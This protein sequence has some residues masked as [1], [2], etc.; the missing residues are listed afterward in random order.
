MS[1]IMGEILFLGLSGDETT[2]PMELRDYADWELR[3]R[4]L[5][6]PGVAQVTPI[7]GELRQVQVILNPG[8]L[9][10]VHIGLR[11]VLDSLQGA[12]QNAPGGFI[13]SGHSEY[14]VRGIGRADTLEDLGQ[15]VVAR[16]HGVP[17]L[18]HQV[19]EIKMGAALAR[20][21]AAVDGEPAIVLAV[22]KQPE[23]NTLAL[24]QRIDDALDSVEAF[25]PA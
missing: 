7:G 14:L 9:E 13:T 5:S 10:S 15:V 3:R 2:D 11:Q 24:T 1:S 22:Q 17:I 20:G 12:N 4:L 23:A 25:L 18:L 19:A 21:T 8:A 6:I 16:V